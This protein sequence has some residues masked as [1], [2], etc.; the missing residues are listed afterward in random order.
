MRRFD[1]KTILI[2][3]GA[4]GIGAATARRFAGEG[5][6]MMLA[7]VNGDAAA[8]FAAELDASGQ[9]VLAAQV[10]VRDVGQVIGVVEETVARLGRIDFLFNNAGIGAYG[11]SPDL[12]P[13]VWHNVLAVDLHSVYYGT[14]A[15][16]PH[17]RRQGGG[18]IVNT[19][20]ISGLF[21]DYGLA[22]YNAAKG[23]VVNYTRTS[24]IDHAKDNIRV[25]AV[26]PGPIETALTS[27]TQQFPAILEE[28]NRNIPM[29]RVGRAEEVAA[30]VAFLC[31]DDASYI[32]GANLVIDGG[33]TAAT[34]QVNYTRVMT[35]GA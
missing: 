3:G 4:S 6:S 18:V 20:S 26:C 28:W 7:D 17:M 11:E 12:D 29:G 13:E 25:N 21:G 33:L 14:R 30:A 2:T 31:S 5:A 24:A 8:A 1:G 10:D 22:A 19:A 15:A 16:V 32:T 34:G 35:G 23:A 27:F 9:S